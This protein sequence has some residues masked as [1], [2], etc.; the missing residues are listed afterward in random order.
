M[1]VIEEQGYDLPRMG[2]RAS[3]A[4]SPF[5][6]GIYPREVYKEGPH[7]GGFFMREVAE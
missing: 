7:P 6:R 2:G 5:F 1:E 3:A 4:R